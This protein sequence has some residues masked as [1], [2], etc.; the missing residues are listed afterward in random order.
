M[1]L[2]TKTLLIVLRRLLR[3]SHRD[4]APVRRPGTASIFI[5]HLDSGSSGDNE[6]EINSLFNPIYN[7]E[8][9]GRRL[10]AS[11][12]HA[13]IVIVSLPLTRNMLEPARRTLQSMPSPFKI[14]M[15]GDEGGRESVFADSY[16][17]IPLP[18][19]LG[20]EGAIRIPPKSDSGQPVFP[21][22]A[23]DILRELIDL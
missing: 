22:P 1:G 19:E 8:Q 10:V 17:I 6:I 13:D 20:R 12:R 2:S 15:L 4:A 16:A 18:E 11:P 3:K 7:I 5:R 9:Y 14:V 23:R 21:P